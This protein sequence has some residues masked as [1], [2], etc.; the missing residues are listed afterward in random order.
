MIDVTEELRHADAVRKQ[1]RTYCTEN[2]FNRKVESFE[3]VE[4]IGPSRSGTTKMG[5]DSQRVNQAGDSLCAP[6]G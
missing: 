2:G 6:Q 3:K 4:T 5:Y 1:K